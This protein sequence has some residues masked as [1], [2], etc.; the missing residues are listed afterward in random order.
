MVRLHIQLNQISLHILMRRVGIFDLAKELRASVLQNN[1]LTRVKSD[2]PIWQKV[3]E[4]AT[5]FSS[6]EISPWHEK[7]TKRIDFNQKL[8]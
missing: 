4:S 3:R 5:N 1:W 7:T 6:T 8:H 2:L